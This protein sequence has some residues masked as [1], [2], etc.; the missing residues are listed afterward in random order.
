MFRKIAIKYLCYKF[1]IAL[2]LFSQ[3][4]YGQ[5]QPVAVVTKIVTS[6]PFNYPQYFVHLYKNTPRE[7]AAVVCC[8]KSIGI[9]AASLL[10]HKVWLQLKKMGYND[11]DALYSA[12]EKMSAEEFLKLLDN[13]GRD[14]V[15]ILRAE[16]AMF[17]SCMLEDRLR[18]LQHIFPVIDNIIIAELKGASKYVLKYF[19]SEYPMDIHN[20][21]IEK[22]AIL[23]AINNVG[24][25]GMEA[26]NYQDVEQGVFSEVI[27]GMANRRF[28]GQDVFASDPLTD[29]IIMGWAVGYATLF[30]YPRP[31]VHN[32][33]TSHRGHK[34]NDINGNNN[35]PDYTA[36]KVIAKEHKILGCQATIFYLNDLLD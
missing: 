4:A 2:I 3:L 14:E 27:E 25:A 31:E 15:N 29:D 11:K 6:F 10:V 7:Q 5:M 8:K 34:I 32:I 1:F 26:L 23:G 33:C 30:I 35:R 9:E 36:N 20:E 24:Y 18:R 22:N 12:V 17:W 13:L 28:S 16:F 19:L 21:N